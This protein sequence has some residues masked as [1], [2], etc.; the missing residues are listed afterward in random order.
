M[1]S[2]DIQTDSPLD[3]YIDV[4]FRLHGLGEWRWK[5]PWE[6]GSTADFIIEFIDPKDQFLYELR[7]GDRWV[8]SITEEWWNNE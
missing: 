7:G 4:V 2:F 5:Y 8:K 6:Y 3:T 1:S